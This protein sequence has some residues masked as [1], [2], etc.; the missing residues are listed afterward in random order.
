M[1][2]WEK[3]ARIQF[4]ANFNIMWRRGKGYEKN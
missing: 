3:K 4:L 2:L 1:E